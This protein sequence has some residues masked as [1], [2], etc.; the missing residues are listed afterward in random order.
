LKNKTDLGESW[1]LADDMQFY[2]IAPIMLLPL[3]VFKSN[4]FVGPIISLFIQ[5]VILIINIVATAL[6]IQANPDA[7]ITGS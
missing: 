2:W 4:L 6:I 1:Y 5:A 7:E 3:V